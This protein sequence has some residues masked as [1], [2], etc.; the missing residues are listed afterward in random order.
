V[1]VDAELARDRDVEYEAIPLALVQNAAAGARRLSLVVLD[2]CRNN[3]FTRRLSRGGDTRA[4]GRGLPE[5]QDLPVNRLVA[6]AAK[7]GSVAAGGA[8]GGHSPF[9][10]ALLEHLGSPGLEVGLLFRKVRDTV[11]ART[12][13]VQ[14]PW[15]YGSLSAESFYLVPPPEPEP[16]PE[17]EPGPP[18]AAA[19]PDYGGRDRVMFEV[20]RDSARAQ[21]FAIFLEGFPESPL[22]PLARSRLEELGGRESGRPPRPCP[23]PRIRCPSPRPCPRHRLPRPRTRPR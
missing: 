22:A 8:P 13:P 23:R 7:D 21:D 11:A 16:E 2:A 4:I 12:D 1:P 17:P 3:P 18:P 10:A 6:Y 15:L 19:S 9:T 20:I 5:P 14:E